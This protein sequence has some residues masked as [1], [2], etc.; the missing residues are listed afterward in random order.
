MY[1]KLRKVVL[2][3][4]E[5]NSSVVRSIGCLSR[6]PRFNSQHPHGNSQLP[7]TSVPGGL[8]LTQTYIPAKHQC[9]LIFFLSS[10]GENFS[11]QVPCPDF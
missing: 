9:T 6:G 4:E 7:V 1:F 3:D 10:F 11:S 8:T 2:G 5:I